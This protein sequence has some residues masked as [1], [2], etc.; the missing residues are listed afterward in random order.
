M[1]SC[2]HARIDFKRP[3]RGPLSSAQCYVP[4]HKPQRKAAPPNDPAAAPGE[5][6]AAEEP[7]P[8]A[9]SEKVTAERL[10]AEAESPEGP[11]LQADPGLSRYEKQVADQ[12]DSDL[13]RTFPNIE[14]GKS[15]FRIQS[16]LFY[17][18]TVRSDRTRSFRRL[19]GMLFSTEVVTTV[20][21]HWM[22]PAS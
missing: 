4:L 18:A 13:P 11:P 21:N 19:L 17:E 8:S 15:A 2:I 12:I 14:A 9:E 5:S 22:R 3:H 16:L 10:T 6:S 1:K 7:L 20:N